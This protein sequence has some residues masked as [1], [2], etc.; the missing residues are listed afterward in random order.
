VLECG[1]NSPFTQGR[2]PIMYALRRKVLVN[3]F[4]LFDLLIAGTCLLLSIVTVSKNPS[5]QS[6][7]SIWEAEIKIQYL[8]FFLLALFSWHLTF[9]YFK[10][11]QSKRLSTQ[12]KEGFDVL[13]ATAIG[14]IIIFVEALFFRINVISAQV[15]VLFWI[16]TAMVT[17]T[18][19]ILLRYFLRWVR[20]RGRNLRRALIIGT[21]SRAIEFGDKLLASPELGYRL[22]G[23][24]DDEWVGFDNLKKTG[25]RLVCD[26]NGFQAFIRN[27]VVDEVII[28]LPLKTLYD[29]AFRIISICE[30]Q[31]IV[32]RCL[33]NIFD[34][35]FSLSDTDF[36]DKNQ[37]ISISHKEIHGYMSLVKRGMDLFL[38]FT[39]ML[40]SLP[41]FVVVSIAIKID[42]EGSVF[43]VQDRVGFGK[44]VFRLYKF[45]TMVMGAEE[46][47]A[48]LEDCNEVCG[49]VFKIVDDPR[50]TTIGKFLRKTSIDELPQLINVLKGDMSFVG[51]RPLPVRDFNGFSED[52]HR[53]RFSVRPGI[54]CLWQIE[55]RS[56]IPFERWMQ[57]DME[58]IDHWSLWLDI[59]VLIKT[60][61][62]VLKGIGAT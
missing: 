37:L 35:S 2:G 44:R 8:V 17:I 36:F 23:F 43:F 29:Q 55:G 26:L 3:A 18:S 54:T 24:V 50:I 48:E 28:A 40:L 62:T 14:A 25:Y 20:V 33:P 7:S 34:V 21:N 51:P 4:K 53:R 46:K 59:K 57:L 32:V 60:I 19:R 31:G 5:I 41:V 11:Y 16:S 13:K 56:N 52:W 30:E 12:S 49:P 9:L 27:L 10:L 61:P 42:S 39:L 15:I 45:R 47:Q 58:Y 22:I 1:E 38:S 6:F